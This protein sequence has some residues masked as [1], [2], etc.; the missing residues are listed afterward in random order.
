MGI[1]NKRVTSLFF[2]VL[3]FVSLRLYCAPAYSLSNDSI[4]FYNF[5]WVFKEANVTRVEVD[6]CWLVSGGNT[7]VFLDGTLANGLYVT[8]GLRE[9][10][11]LRL[12]S[13]SVFRPNVTASPGEG[14]TVQNGFEDDTYSIGFYNFSLGE[15]YRLILYADGVSVSG[16]V[17]RHSTE[18]LT[19]VC[20]F[21]TGANSVF[22]GDSWNSVSLE[23]FG[24]EDPSANKSVISISSPLRVDVLGNKIGATGGYVNYQV[25]YAK[26]DVDSDANG[27]III[28]HGGDTI[29]DGTPIDNGYIS[30]AASMP[31]EPILISEFPSV[32]VLLFSFIL[33]S[34][35][36]ILL[37][38]KKKYMLY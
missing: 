4:N 10:S 5:D 17:F 21:Y 35:L 11:G 26:S 7:F 15:K 32:L 34:T 27:N 29:N 14:F 2:I 28:S 37:I 3:F 18:D 9:V 30:W 23:H 6:I 38:K 22:R 31:P 20:T 19:K 1:S 24:M 8:I 36:V 12:A 33:A 25:F 13:M 16:Y